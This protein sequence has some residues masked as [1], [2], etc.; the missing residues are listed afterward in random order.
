MGYHTYKIPKGTLGQSSKILEELH[1]LIDAEAQGSKI[2]I[3]NELSD[4]VGAILAYL[5]TNHPSITI[6]DLIQMA[7]LTKSAFEDGTRCSLE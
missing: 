6:S 4:M 7:E 5:S 1:E 3:L 2:L